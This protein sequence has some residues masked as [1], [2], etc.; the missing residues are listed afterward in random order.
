MTVRYC[1]DEVVGCATLTLRVYQEESGYEYEYASDHHEANE[2]HEEAQ[3]EPGVLYQSLGE[4]AAER[5]VGGE[6]RVVMGCFGPEHGC[7][8]HHNPNHERHSG[9][10]SE[11]SDVLCVLADR[12]RCVPRRADRGRVAAA[13]PRG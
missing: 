1:Y 10:P 6:R 8:S 5:E 9:S 2:G 4:K 11:P 3:I 13:G 7:G 12:R